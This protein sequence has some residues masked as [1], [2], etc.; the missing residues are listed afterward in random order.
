MGLEQR[1]GN[2][3]TGRREAMG[4]LWAVLRIQGEEKA[5]EGFVFF[6]LYYIVNSLKHKGSYQI[7]TID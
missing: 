5:M 6:H 7:S 1:E 3:K 4:I 2:R